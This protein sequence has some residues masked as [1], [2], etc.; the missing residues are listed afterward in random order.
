MTVVFHFV[1]ASMTE[2]DEYCQSQ[3]HHRTHS[4]RTLVG[5]TL[6]ITLNRT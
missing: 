6:P 1:E 5:L 3:T 4:N 2:V